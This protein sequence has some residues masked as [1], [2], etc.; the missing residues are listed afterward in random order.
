MNND[1]LP[2]AAISAADCISHI[3]A[4]RHRPSL[5][6]TPEQVKRTVAMCHNLRLAEGD[7]WDAWIKSLMGAVWA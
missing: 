2:H 3:E 4:M 5:T 7:A 1:T 6:V